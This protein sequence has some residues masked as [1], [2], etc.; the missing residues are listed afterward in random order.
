MSAT[1][2]LFSQLVASEECETLISESASD[3]QNTKLLMARR[4]K[5]MRNKLKEVKMI[6]IYSERI[7]D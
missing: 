2:T 7:L 3:I 6:W 4:K 1:M 5:A